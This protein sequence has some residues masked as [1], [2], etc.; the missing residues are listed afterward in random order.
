MTTATNI[1]LA[2][3]NKIPQTC[4]KC[5]NQLFFERDFYGYYSVCVCGFSKDLEIPVNLP[6]VHGEKLR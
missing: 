5:G 1:I 2:Q 6:K 4:P 3:H